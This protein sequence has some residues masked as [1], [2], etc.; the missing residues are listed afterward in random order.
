MQKDLCFFKVEYARLSLIMVKY[1]EDTA[2][3]DE[4]AKI[5]QEVQVHKHIKNAFVIDNSG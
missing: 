5:L 1:K 2:N 3:I 4:A